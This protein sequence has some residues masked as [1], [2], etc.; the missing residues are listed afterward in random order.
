MCVSDWGK[1]LG[2]FR[3]HEGDIRFERS[4]QGG[5]RVVQ[6]CQDDEG[7]ERNRAEPEHNT[8][9]TGNARAHSAFTRQARSSRCVTSRPARWT[10]VSA[11]WLTRFPRMGIANLAKASGGTTRAV[12]VD[13]E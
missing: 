3:R 7:D 8:R 4:K 10:M 11:Y 9:R 2:A 13:L 12:V 5:R 1:G 6:A